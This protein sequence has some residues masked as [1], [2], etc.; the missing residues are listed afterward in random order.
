MSRTSSNALSSSITRVTTSGVLVS[1]SPRKKLS[2]V[3]LRSA[4]VHKCLGIQSRNDHR[5]PGQSAH[6]DALPGDRA[7]VVAALRAHILRHKNIPTRP[8]TVTGQEER[9]Q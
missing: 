6:V 4:G 7:T 8:A 5:Q 3:K 1:P 9:P 2:R